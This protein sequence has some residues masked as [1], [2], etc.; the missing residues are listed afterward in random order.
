MRNSIIDKDYF[1]IDYIRRS[2]ETSRNQITRSFNMNAATTGN[3]I[4]RLLNESIIIEDHEAVNADLAAAGRPPITLR[5]NPDAAYFIGVNFSG[6][7]LCA[8][9]ADFAG[10]PV[11]TVVKDFAHP[12]RKN[13][14]LGALNAA[15]RELL[16]LGKIDPKKL[17]GIGIGAPGIVNT[18]TGCAL[19]YNRIK[20]WE[21]VNLADILGPSFSLPVFVEHNSNCFALGEVNL[22]VARQYGN[23]VNIVIRTG[24]AMGIIRN[25]EVFAMSPLSAGELGHITINPKGSK[26]WCG[27]N[28]CLET[29]IS[30]WVLAK[31]LRK[32]A[33]GG[34]IPS[35]PE[36]EEFVR[37]AVA[38]DSFAVSMLGEMFDYLG[39]AIADITRLFRPEAIV[40]NGN[41]NPAKELMRERITRVMTERASLNGDAPEII[42]S[43]NDDTIGACGAA[44]MAISRLYNPIRALEIT[45]V[46]FGVGG[47]TPNARREE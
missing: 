31:K 14:V 24:I 42:I 7:S 11:E 41:F 35:V 5:L 4:E 27:N 37:M 25:R 3:I 1:L 15:V 23:I 22:G 47:K 29:F 8:V 21:N 2:R 30:G 19:K 10:N 38:G 12:V 44:L 26:C 17:E 33:K 13:I 34:I 18:Q 20:S 43:T 45:N 16:E 39:I 36:T 32:A 6:D 9:L 40:I 28:G 46:P